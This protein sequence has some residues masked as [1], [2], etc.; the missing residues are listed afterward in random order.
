MIYL[1]YIFYPSELK[2]LV[3]NLNREK[4]LIKQP[5]V[6][7]N[8]GL[9]L[10][11]ILFGIPVTAY[12]MFEDIEALFLFL[13]SS[14]IIIYSIRFY[15]YRFILPASVGKLTRGKVVSEPVLKS[16]TPLPIPFQPK[17]WLVKYSTLNSKTKNKI[18]WVKFPES[19]L[20]KGQISSG[21]IVEILYLENNPNYNIP[22]IKG[23]IE[24]Y[25]IKKENN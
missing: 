23:L 9:L 6:D 2:K 15:S 10:V 12:K 20:K 21:N 16:N 11:T 5:L 4:K 24:K 1:F 8:K 3:K 19:Y 13:L 25:N 17:V 7:L 18:F 14:F 22:N